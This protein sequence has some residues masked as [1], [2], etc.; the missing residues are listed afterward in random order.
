[1]Q[2]AGSALVVAASAS[3]LSRS[4]K[5][6]GWTPFAIDGFGDLDTREY[7]RECQIVPL[8]KSGFDA[9]ALRSAIDGMK[10]TDVAL[11][12]GGLDS[13]PG[14]IEHLARGRLLVGNTA[15]TVRL[16]K[17]PAM[18]F[19]LLA[20]LGIPFP[21]TRFDPPCNVCGWL[22]KH[23]GSEGGVAVNFASNTDISKPYR[24]FQRQLETLP[25]S[26]LFLADGT[27]SRIIGF[28]TL[29]TTAADPLLPFR[30]AGAINRTSLSEPQRETLRGIV[31]QLVS[32]LRLRGLNSLDFMTDETGG[33]RVLE[34]N[35]RPSATLSLYDDELPSGLAGL[36][37]RACLGTLPDFTLAAFP[38]RA[39]QIVY[40]PHDVEMPGTLEW[41]A[42]CQNRPGP[43]CRI[44]K[45]A[46]LC[47]I[48]ADG[49]D[50]SEVLSN[51][52][53]R[54]TALIQTMI[55]ADRMADT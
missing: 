17:T 15:E 35:P 26:A 18:F 21:E 10:P 38:A 13:L 34:L 6:A 12:G 45:G 37:I 19:A 36:H 2:E 41:P 11:Y 5:R 46:P 22:V 40:A 33:I 25:M 53:A 54:H 4:L 32:A 55:A 49:T 24:Y 51:L 47:T 42:W 14:V 48:T 50:E 20:N 52:A 29:W 23:G 3:A 30:F 7:C 9:S 28:N 39:I 16:A 8:G 43:G 1:M 31:A 27:E 44:A